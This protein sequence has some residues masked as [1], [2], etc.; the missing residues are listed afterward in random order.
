MQITTIRLH[1]VYAYEKK[2]SLIQDNLH[3][4]RWS[5]L[6]LVF[7]FPILLCFMEWSAL[8]I[9]LISTVIYYSSH[10]CMFPRLTHCPHCCTFMGADKSESL[11]LMDY[12]VSSPF[13]IIYPYFYISMAATEQ[14]RLLHFPEG[15]CNKGN[16][17]YP[18]QL[19]IFISSKSGC[20]KQFRWTKPSGAYFSP[21]SRGS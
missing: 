4:V 9:S 1:I 19:Q 21:M 11:E 3:L 17:I 2:I 8:Q 12:P 14:H 20:L 13:T 5:C 6:V 10:F 15:Q 16:G 7:S 18:V